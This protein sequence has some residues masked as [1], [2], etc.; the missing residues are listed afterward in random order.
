MPCLE[1]VVARRRDVRLLLAGDGSLRAS[2]LQAARERGLSDYIRWLGSLSLPDV[3][4]LFSAADVVVGTHL[5]ATYLEA[6]LCGAPLVAYDIDRHPEF[7]HDG[8]T[9]MLAPFRDAQR[10]SEAVLRVL[11]DAALADRLRRGAK[12]RVLE[13]HR[14]EHYMEDMRRCFQELLGV[15]A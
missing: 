14:P 10:L 5:G 7:I 12:R 4:D 1:R 9:G 2:L 3:L 13:Q 11:D 8:E 6:A 15:V